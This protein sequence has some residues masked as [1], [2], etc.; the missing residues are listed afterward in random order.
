MAWDYRQKK[1]NIESLA[2][3]LGASI[4][5]TT[6]GWASSPH[7]KRARLPPISCPEAYAIALHELGHISYANG[8]GE[9]YI[10]YMN[11]Q[12]KIGI[13]TGGTPMMVL[14]D[15]F[16]AW[17]WA[18]AH[19]NFTTTMNRVMQSSLEGYADR[20]GVVPYTDDENKVIGMAGVWK[21]IKKSEGALNRWTEVVD[22][23]ELK[24][25]KLAFKLGL[26]TVSPRDRKLNDLLNAIKTSMQQLS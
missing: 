6:T 9:L 18:K 26:K 23:T 14:I 5:W 19:A 16:K 15:E 20:T 17:E 2:K 21:Y 8:R 10:K 4:E 13:I 24:I 22:K 25:N 12:R 7:D 11:L 1:R 3:K